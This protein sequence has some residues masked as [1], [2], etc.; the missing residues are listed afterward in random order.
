[1][2]EHY[3]RQKLKTLYVNAWNIVNKI[4][5]LKLLIETELPEIICITETCLTNELS[6]E[7]LALN[8]FFVVNHIDTTGL[9]RNSREFL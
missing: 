8:D 4:D 6:D 5:D 3:K 1:M 9:Q 7:H 2:L